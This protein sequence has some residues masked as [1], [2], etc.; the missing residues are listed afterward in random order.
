MSEATTRAMRYTAIV[1]KRLWTRVEE[2]RIRV[3]PSTTPLCGVGLT[4]FIG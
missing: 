3:S 4:D 1:G 2:E